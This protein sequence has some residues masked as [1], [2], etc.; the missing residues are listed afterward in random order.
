MY[1]NVFR[2]ECII[3]GNRIA[4]YRLDKT[5]EGFFIETEICGSS[6]SERVFLGN[7][8]DEKAA[9]IAFLL[10]EKSVHPLHIEDILRD[11]VL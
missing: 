8:C 11:M 6:F 3:T 10:A 1:T 5:E 2:T 9:E 7:C 4:E